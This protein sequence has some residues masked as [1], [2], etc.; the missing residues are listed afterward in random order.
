MGKGREHQEIDVDEVVVD[1]VDEIVGLS[2]VERSLETLKKYFEQ[3]PN[4]ACSHI[5]SIQG[6]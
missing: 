5:M 3:R 4:D 6:L 2:C 1:V